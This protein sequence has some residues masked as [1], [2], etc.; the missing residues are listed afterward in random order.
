MKKKVVR[1]FIAIIAISFSL[2]G[3][4]YTEE[5]EMVDGGNPDIVIY[6]YKNKFFSRGCKYKPGHIC[7]IKGGHPELPPIEV[8]F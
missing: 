8:H 1:S 3:N 6:E 4:A 7:V 2:Q 5:L